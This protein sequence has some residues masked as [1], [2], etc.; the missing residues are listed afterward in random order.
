MGY[1][2]RKQAGERDFIDNFYRS[3]EEVDKKAKAAAAKVSKQH[4]KVVGDLLENFGL[5]LD[6]KRSWVEKY[7]VGSDSWGI[8]GALFVKGDLPQDGVQ[9]ALED[10]ALP[11]RFPKVYKSGDFWIGEFDTGG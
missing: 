1:D 9:M 4:L 3:L 6:L 8:Q 7:S 5:T 2:F 10:V 11:L